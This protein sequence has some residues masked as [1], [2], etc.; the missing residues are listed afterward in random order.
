MDG[1]D[2]LVM[3]GRCGMLFGGGWGGFSGWGGGLDGLL[4]SGGMLVFMVVS[5]VW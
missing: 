4:G 3:G 1:N 2:G 5:S